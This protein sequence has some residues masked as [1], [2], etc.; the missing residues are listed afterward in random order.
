LPPEKTVEWYLRKNRVNPQLP[1]RLAA[2]DVM[3]E[4]CKCN[5]DAILEITA[6][7][8]ANLAIELEIIEQKLPIELEQAKL[9]IETRASIVHTEEASRDLAALKLCKAKCP[10]LSIDRIWQ[11][12]ETLIQDLLI[13]NQ[14]KKAILEGVRDR[15]TLEQEL[16][17]LKITTEKELEPYKKY[18][19]EVTEFLQK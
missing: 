11:R 18:K 10:Q 7:D 15:P 12:V 9:N 16:Q 1:A 5:C 13:E 6:L 4:E 3:Q 8:I 19:I 2:V 14:L 17:A